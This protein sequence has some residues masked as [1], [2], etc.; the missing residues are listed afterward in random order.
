MEDVLGQEEAD[1]SCAFDHILAP[2]GMGEHFTLPPVAAK[3]LRALGVS[4]WS[5]SATT[6]KSPPSSRSWPWGSAGRCLPANGWRKG[7]MLKAGFTKEQMVLDRQPAPDI[8]GDSVDVAI[9]VVIDG[10]IDTSADAAAA[11]LVR[12][13]AALFEYHLDPGD[14]LA[15]EE[16]VPVG[17]SFGQQSGSISARHDRIWRIRVAISELQGAGTSAGTRC[18]G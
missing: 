7:A 2:E 16:Q 12:V 14:D 11:A 18:G 17:L 4:R 1:V 10:V 13:R 15:D 3:H 5:V 6:M 9:Y 8:Q